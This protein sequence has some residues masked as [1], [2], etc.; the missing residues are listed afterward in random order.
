MSK[1][2]RNNIDWLLDILDSIEKILRYTDGMAY[3]DFTA[4]ELV[5]DAVLR[6]SLIHI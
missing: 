4:N 2:D 6:L 1:S 5:I 3:Q